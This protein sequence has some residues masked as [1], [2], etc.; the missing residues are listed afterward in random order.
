MMRRVRAMIYVVAAFGMRQLLSPA[1]S[2]CSHI[3][4]HVTIM[5]KKEIPHLEDRKTSIAKILK[6]VMPFDPGVVMIPGAI[7]RI[8]GK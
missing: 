3:S 5:H 8:S 6:R 7:P 4:M 2:V 1:I